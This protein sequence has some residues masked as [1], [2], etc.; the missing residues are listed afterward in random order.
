MNRSG[1]L[2]RVSSPISWSS[3]YCYCYHEN[4]IVFERL[5]EKLFSLWDEKCD[6][7]T[8]TRTNTRQSIHPFRWLLW[9]I[10]KDTHHL[11][12]LKLKTKGCITKSLKTD[13]KSKD[14]GHLYAQNQMKSMKEDDDD[15][16]DDFWWRWMLT[17]TSGHCLEGGLSRFLSKAGWTKW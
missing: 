11:R 13:L 9:T 10:F 2:S 7:R 6:R 1:W 3:W 16:N 5:G 15:D 17:M 8:N 12:S 4:V 14:Q